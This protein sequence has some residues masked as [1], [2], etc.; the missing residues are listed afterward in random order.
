MRLWLL[1][2]TMSSI[3]KELSRASSSRSLRIESY[4]SYNYAF[5]LDSA[6]NLA[7]YSC[8]LDEFAKLDSSSSILE[9]PENIERFISC[10]IQS[11][12]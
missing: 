3:M 7:S 5:N 10:I 6:Y 12:W 1:F 8:K 2:V 9:N 11:T 4:A